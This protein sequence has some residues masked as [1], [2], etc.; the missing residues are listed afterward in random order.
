MTNCCFPAVLKL[1]DC[2]K[3]GIVAD[4]ST[5]TGPESEDEFDRQLRALTEGSA[6]EA[7]FKELSAAEREK[8]GARRAREARKRA[9]RSARHAPRAAGAAGRAGRAG[10][11]KGGKGGKGAGGGGGER[12]PVGAPAR[13]VLLG[14]L[15]IVV[16][17]AFVSG[18]AWLSLHRAGLRGGPT[19]AQPTAPSVTPAFTTSR[20]VASGPPADPFAA[21]PAEHW[22]DGEAGIV[23]PASRPVGDYSAAQVAAAYQTTRMLLIAGYLDRPTLLGGAPTAFAALLT[24]TQ[25]KWFV[26]N[27][28]KTGRDSR[29]DQVSTRGVIT[30][31]APGS[32][33]LIG[34]VIKVTGTMSARPGSAN[35]RK[36]L[37]IEVNYRFVYPVEPPRAPA[38]W[39]TIITQLHGSVDFGYWDTALTGLM[40]W[41]YFEAF[42]AGARCDTSDGYVHPQY[43]TGPPDKVQPSG[44]AIDP[45]A[46]ST[47]VPPPGCDKVT[48]T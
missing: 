24:A 44:A 19:G 12:Q 9:A 1:S 36:A 34:S 42:Q 11:G 16:A 28:D 7:R 29:G 3:F 21:S 30:S 10:G 20:A 22:A 33:Q 5:G 31:F 48:G 15:I 38:D 27:L 39:T 32:T 37:V 18:A 13:R 2:S 14:S 45:Y 6:G 40:P 8:E 4:E 47:A 46:T 23:V 43:A 41:E 25:R 35:G 26:A 17:I